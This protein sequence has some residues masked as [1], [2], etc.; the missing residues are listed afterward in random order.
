VQVPRRFP[1]LRSVKLL[2]MVPVWG[3]GVESGEKP[4][5]TCVRGYDTA[6][7]AGPWG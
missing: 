6:G 4:P 1:S 2:G 7:M 3:E 5:L